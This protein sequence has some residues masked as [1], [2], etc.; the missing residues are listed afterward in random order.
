[1]QINNKKLKYR[2]KVKIYLYI[3]DMEKQSPRH[4]FEEIALIAKTINLKTKTKKH[5]SNQNNDERKELEKGY[6]GARSA[7]LEY[8]FE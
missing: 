5:V 4:N 2:C 6:A 3:C 8:S 7:M 1:M